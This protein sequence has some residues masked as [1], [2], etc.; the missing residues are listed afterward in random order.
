MRTYVIGDVQGCLD[1]LLQLLEKIQFDPQKD[2]LWF[3][4]DLANR[5][6]KPLETLRFIRSLPHTVCVLGNHDLAL[7]LIAE[8]LITPHAEDTQ[9]Q[10]LE[11][12]DKEKLLTWLR[13]CPLYHHCP[14]LGFTLTH[15]GIY[16]EWDLDQ[17]KALAL[18]VENVLQGPQYLDLLK[19]MFGNHPVHWDNALKEW[20]RARFIINAFTRMRF[21]TPE[22]DLVLHAKGS[23]TKHPDLVPWFIHRAKKLEKNFSEEKLIFGHWAALENNAGHD[24][25]YPLDSGCV[26]GKCLTAFCLETQQYNSVNCLFPS[27]ANHGKV[28]PAGN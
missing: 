10:I 6:P 15:A 19:N 5:G 17:A 8:G 22:G 4:G 27:E 9:A 7:L 20:D 24:F 11:A 13:H 1:P 28:R 21:C 25:I 2:T 12:P 18:E 16:P 26:W 3:T 23:M 14:K